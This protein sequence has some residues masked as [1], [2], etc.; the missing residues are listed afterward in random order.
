MASPLQGKRIV[1]TGGAGFLGR[2]V[3]QRLQVLGASDVLIP[4]RAG[5]DL[6]TETG[7]ERLYTEMR[8]Q[9]VLHLAAEVGGIGANMMGGARV[10][11]D[12]LL[13]NNEKPRCK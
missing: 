2:A 6:T 4:R 11:P 13:Y 9:I 3:C 10:V 8:P 1:V 7:V 12:A 5:F